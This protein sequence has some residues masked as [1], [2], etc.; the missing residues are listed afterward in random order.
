MEPYE[1]EK[2]FVK[3]NRKSF[4]ASI[5]L[6]LYSLVGMRQRP[7]LMCPQMD[8]LYQSRMIDERMEH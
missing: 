8:L 1:K 7:M 5:T 6:S 4:R 3:N 2:A